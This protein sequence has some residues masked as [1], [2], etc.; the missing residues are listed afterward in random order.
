M[1]ALSLIIGLNNI[2][3]GISCE[4]IYA[5][6]TRMWFS[7][8]HIRNKVLCGNIEIDVKRTY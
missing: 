5:D 2:C 8:I 7:I 1:A 6:F 3:S 4:T